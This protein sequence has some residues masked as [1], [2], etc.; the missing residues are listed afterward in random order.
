VPQIRHK[1]QPRAGFNPLA[2][3]LNDAMISGPVRAE[4][5]LAEVLGPFWAPC[6]LVSARAYLRTGHAEN[7]ARCVLLTKQWRA[8]RRDKQTPACRAAG[9]LWG[10]FSGPVN[11][12][13]RQEEPSPSDARHAT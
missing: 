1:P 11:Q 7:P 6:E 13:T 12:Q 8:R 2:R 9:S 4:R 10:H 5:Q 3:V